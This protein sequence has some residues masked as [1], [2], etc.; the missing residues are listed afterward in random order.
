MVA[1][2][3]SA[4]SLP[5]TTPSG[6]TSSDR[7]SAFF[8]A[9]NS[10]D[11][12]PTNSALSDPV[13]PFSSVNRSS[14]ARS[15]PSCTEH[16]IRE[17]L[18]ARSSIP[19]PPDAASRSNGARAL[20]S[21]VKLTKNSRSGGICS[22]TS[23]SVTGNCPTRIPSIRCAWA[24][25]SSAFDANATPPIA[26]RPVVNA[27]IFTTTLPPSSSAARAASSGD[28]A[29]RPRGIAIPAPARIA[30]A[31]CSCSRAM[32]ETSLPGDKSDPGMDCWE[33]GRDLQG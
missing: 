29:T 22:S 28:R 14:A 16:E 24:D 6:L 2:P 8:A 30:L 32:G 1:R 20:S 4:T 25:A 21:I 23:T 17:M 12:V 31:W 10:R 7:A 15:G 9:S 5:F 26:F 11:I 19:V 27:W 3:S 18:R 13:R 33:A